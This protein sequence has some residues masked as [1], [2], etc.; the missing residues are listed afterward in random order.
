MGRAI[1]VTDHGGHDAETVARLAEMWR[2]FPGWMIWHGKFTA[3]WW[4]QPP[5]WHP[6]RQLINA[7]SLDSLAVKLGEVAMWQQPALLA[8][9]HG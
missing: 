9:H 1:I 6:Y 4:A 3:S 8:A 2:I 7:P 5:V